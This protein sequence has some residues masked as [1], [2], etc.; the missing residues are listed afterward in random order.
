MTLADDLTNDELRLALGRAKAALAKKELATEELAAAVYQAAKDAALA[1]PPVKVPAARAPRKGVDK[2]AALLHTTDWQLGKVTPDFDSVIL[3][4]RLNRMIDLTLTLRERHGHPVDHCT[5][6]LGGD[7]IEGMTIFPGQA[8][9]INQ[10]IYDQTF[11][12]AHYIVRMV[13][14]LLAEFRTV[15]VSMKHG[16]HGRVGKFGEL[17]DA[18]N[19][20]RMAY[21][22]AHDQ[23]LPANAKRLTW[24]SFAPD[25]MSPFQIGAYKALLMHGNEFARTFSSQRIVG[26]LT[27]WQT[28][29][30]R[31]GWTDAYLGHFHRRDTYGLPGG[32]HAFLT[33]S[34]ESSNAYAAEV[35]AA[36]GKPSQ[37]LHFV[38]GA[39]G[40]VTAEHIIW[41]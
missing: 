26:K 18:D 4:E 6:L 36:V 28:H 8:W 33:G 34:P 9:E 31:G 35:L 11:M 27:A 29:P 38:D 25:F 17:P 22:I 21:R 3:G 14:R 32:G 24:Q 12:A 37:R 10:G 19:L 7:M 40:L 2:H 41:L 16:N 23:L 15:A 39:A 20:D 13:T 30:D 1:L 5:L